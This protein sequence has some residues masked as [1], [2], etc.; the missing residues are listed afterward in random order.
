MTKPSNS[1]LKTIAII[2]LGCLTAIQWG[3]GFGDT[4]RKAM[5]AEQVKMDVRVCAVE[6]KQQAKDVYD[7]AFQ[8]EVRLTLQQ[9]TRDLQ[10]IKAGLRE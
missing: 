7:A 2:V 5:A 6:T 1:D 3:Y 10:E 8:A 9:V 4:N